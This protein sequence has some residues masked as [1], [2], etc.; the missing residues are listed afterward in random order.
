MDQ[1]EVE[2]IHLGINSRFH[3][4][5]QIPVGSSA[6]QALDAS[7]VFVDCPE[8]PPDAPIGIYGQKVQRDL[9]VKNGD[10]IEIY[11]PLVFDPKQARRNRAA[12]KNS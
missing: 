8:L 7:G 4:A 11:R 9:V 3:R 10:R 5:L 2:I 6:Q 1:I 12:R